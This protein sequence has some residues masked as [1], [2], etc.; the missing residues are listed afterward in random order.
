MTTHGI[1]ALRGRHRAAR[2][3]STIIA[4]LAAVVGL[5]AG[6]LPTIVNSVVADATDA[7]CSAMT[8]PVVNRVSPAGTQLLTTHR[9]QAA[10]TAARRRHV[11]ERTLFKASNHR[12]AGLLPLIRLAKPKAHDFLYTTSGREAA[13]AVRNSGYVR[14]GVAF[15]VSGKPADCATPVFRFRKHG[16]HRFVLDGGRRRL[17]TAGWIPEG[18]AWYAAPTAPRSEP[19]PTTPESTTP[20]PVPSDTTTAPAG[21]TSTPTSATATP[22][23]VTPPA[24]SS[25]SSNDSGSGQPAPLTQSLYVQSANRNDIPAYNMEAAGSPTKLLLWQLAN[26][27]TGMWLGGSANDAATVNNVVTA[28][29]AAHQT[30]TFVLYAIPNRDC[31]GPYSKGG[32]PSEA[33]YESWVRSIHDA[34]A[35]RPAI[36]IIEPDAIGYGSCPTAQQAERI[37]ELQ[38][39]ID[40][41]AIASN[42]NVVAYLHAGSSGINPKDMANALTRVG[43]EKIRGFA[44]NVSGHDVTS[45]EV[46]YGRAIDAQLGRNQPFVIDTSRNGD[47]RQP[48]GSCNP[49][50]QAVGTR[51]TTDPQISGVDALLWLHTP[52]GSDGQCHPGD[53]PAGTFVPDW[54]AQYVQAAIAKNLITEYPE[55]VY[56]PSS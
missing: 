34:I 53:P 54:A 56:A 41:F 35:G 24:S 28:A 19:V 43:I 49:P 47:G 5:V 2:R 12:S 8:V 48:G 44:L 51:P 46:T 40:T 38:F 36:V 29:A 21:S 6:F 3:R 14:K 37:A 32:L 23:V 9:S 31:S 16:R 10:K 33:A 55:G 39:D 30:P 52:G 50:V 11:S 4:L 1:R 18:V 26:T 42:P 7:R 25:S 22:P 15:Y 20:A 45:S 17:R 27:Q 13:Q